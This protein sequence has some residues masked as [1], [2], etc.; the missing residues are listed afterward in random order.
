V[1]DEDVIELLELIA[2][3][4]RRTGLGRID[5]GTVGSPSGEAQIL[6][7]DDEKKMCVCHSLVDPPEEPEIWMI[8]YSEKYTGQRDSSPDDTENCVAMK[9]DI[10]VEAGYSKGK[11]AN[12]MSFIRQFANESLRRHLK[13]TDQE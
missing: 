11:A 7:L 1:A 13:I 5:L 12:A 2:K 10:L 4:G 3:Q 6:F 9:E 8:F